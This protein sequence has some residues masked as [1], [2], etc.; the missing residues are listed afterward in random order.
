MDGWHSGRR[1]FSYALTWD[2]QS[3]IEPY[4]EVAVQL[5][6]PPTAV[7]LNDPSHTEWTPIDYKLAK[8]H[9]LRKTYGDVPPWIDRSDRVSWDVKTFTSR[10]AAAI[11][12]KQASEK[13]QV[14]GRRYYA[15][16]RTVDGGPLPTM[17]EFLEEQQRL[18][19]SKFR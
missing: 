5:G 1:F 9:T 11:E 8:A 17:Q 16:P 13:K 6:Q 12:K 3:Y 18:N 2:D 15:V 14:P 4:L 7:I 19:S 10:S